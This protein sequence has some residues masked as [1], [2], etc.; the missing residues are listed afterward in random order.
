MGLDFED[1]LDKVFFD[2]VE[3]GSTLGKLF[4]MELSLLCL[5]FF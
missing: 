3:S 5:V 2:L 1:F 4:E